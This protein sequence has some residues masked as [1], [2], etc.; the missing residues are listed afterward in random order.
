MAQTTYSFKPLAMKP[1]NSVAFSVPKG[2]AISPDGAF[3]AAEHQNQAAIENG[4]SIQLLGTLPGSSYSHATGIAANADAVVGLT[5]VG[6]AFYW[7]PWNGMTALG[8]LPGQSYSIAAD[9]SEMGDAVIGTSGSNSS[10]NEGFFW[11]PYTGMQGLGFLPGYTSSKGT[12]ISGNG[13]SAT[14]YCEGNSNNLVMAFRWEPGILRSLGTLPGYNRSYGYG[15][16]RT[17]DFVV[18]SAD[19]NST[20]IQGFIWNKSSGMKGIGAIP[21]Y[22]SSVLRDVSEKGVRSVGFATGNSGAAAILY[23]S[24]SGQIDILQDLL[25]AKGVNVRGWQLQEATSISD[26][27]TTIAG[28]GLNPRGRQ[29]YWRV[30]IP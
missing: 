24:Q 21:G 10:T 2:L 22:T 19:L 16:S 12:A 3:A 20:L 7:T 4:G 26:D 25:L 15:I 30:T 6:A 18:G 5:D 17:G 23:N 29:M 9:V 14:G 11:S 28:I 8:T 13:Q 1:I 27:G